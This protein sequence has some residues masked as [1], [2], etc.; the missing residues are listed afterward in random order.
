[1]CQNVTVLNRIARSKFLLAV[2]EQRR[3]DRAQP[4]WRSRGAE[5]KL[6][7]LRQQRSF[8]WSSIVSQ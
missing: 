7:T 5:M 4:V 2:S 1:V 6:R 3:F 8:R